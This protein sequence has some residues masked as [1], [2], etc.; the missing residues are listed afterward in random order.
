MRGAALPPPAGVAC[1]GMRYGALLIILIA[2]QAYIYIHTI[3]VLYVVC[4]AFFR[5][6]F[7]DS[8]ERKPALEYNID[9]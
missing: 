5:Q 7:D 6:Y 9:V 4:S 3:G 1:A 8:T 2:Y